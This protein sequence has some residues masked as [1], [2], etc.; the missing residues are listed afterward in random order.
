MTLTEHFQNCQLSLRWLIIGSTSS[1]PNRDRPSHA[2][3]GSF[4][5]WCCMTVFPRNILSQCLSVICLI[6]MSVYLA[7]ICTKALGLTVKEVLWLEE[8]H[9]SLSLLKWGLT[10]FLFFYL[11]GLNQVCTRQI[12]FRICYKTPIFSETRVQYNTQFS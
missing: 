10:C 9:C 12:F 8:N 1:F 7:I 4:Q 11:K 6:K 5:M 3:S 2:A